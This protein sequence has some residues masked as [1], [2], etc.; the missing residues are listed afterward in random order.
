MAV[1]AA[2]ARGVTGVCKR[3]AQV[4]LSLIHSVPL[5]WIFMLQFSSF[6]GKAESFVI[7]PPWANQAA[8]PCSA[9]SWQLLY[10]PGDKK[11]YQ[12]FEQGPCPRSQELAFNAIN[13][14]AE[15]RCPKDLLY[16]PATD[17][18]DQ[19]RIWEK[20]IRFKCLLLCFRCYPEYGKGPCELNQYLEKSSETDRV[21][22]RT[23][24]LCKNGRIFWPSEAKCYELYS[25]G[26]CHK[27]NL[28]IRE[29]PSGPLQIMALFN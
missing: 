8:N 11:C 15:C 2:G 16:W 19:S 29:Y 7:A 1:N 5:L 3:H 12:I 28:E 10:W 24:E 6:A 22:C 17:R 18:S 13:K 27:V 20:L 26:P 21:Q 25:Q 14:R 4:L 23:M 9:T